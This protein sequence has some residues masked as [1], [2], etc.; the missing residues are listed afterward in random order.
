[1]YDYPQIFKSWKKSWTMFYGHVWLVVGAFVEI[2][3]HITPTLLP[4][5]PPRWFA[6]V[7][8]L[9]ALATYA[10]RIKTTT[11]LK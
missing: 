8:L 1:M 6:L 10:L 9:N 11:A 4:F 2:A 3:P 7:A 5:V